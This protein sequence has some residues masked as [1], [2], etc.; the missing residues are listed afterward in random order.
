VTE[1]FAR[2]WF[3]E[4]AAE[5]EG[6]E[7]FE[8]ELAGGVTGQFRAKRGEDCGVAAL[9]EDLAGALAPPAVFMAEEFDEG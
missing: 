7:S 6:P 1:K 2:E 3:V 8:G 4:T 5:M 9:C